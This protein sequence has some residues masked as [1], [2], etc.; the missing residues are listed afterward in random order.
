M[1][2]PQVTI[3]GFDTGF[4]DVFDEL[5]ISDCKTS[6]MF[7]TYGRHDTVNNGPPLCPDVIAMRH[8]TFGN[9]TPAELGLWYFEACSHSYIRSHLDVFQGLVWLASSDSIWLSEK[10]RNTLIKGIIQRDQWFHR[11]V[12]N[13]DDELIQALH[14]LSRKNFKLSKRFVAA[15]E[16]NVGYTLKDLGLVDS[17]RLTAR[18]LLDRDLIGKYVAYREK[19][20]YKK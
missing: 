11:I 1:Y 17:P 20:R 13:L 5:L 16:E 12:C 14:G 15:L 2:A 4:E 6:D 7:I 9:Y 19:F 18:S 10:V 8:R 3:P